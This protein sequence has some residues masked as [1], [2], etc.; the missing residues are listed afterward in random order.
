MSV[1]VQSS[2]VI[3]SYSISRSTDVSN[4][5][6]AVESGGCYILT[7]ITRRGLRVG[8]LGA[9]LDVMFPS[10]EAGSPPFVR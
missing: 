6:P 1:L 9:W 2:A 4:T 10:A 7:A 5:G 3:S 8:F